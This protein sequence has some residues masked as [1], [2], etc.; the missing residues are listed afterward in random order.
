[1]LRI[2]LLFTLTS[3]FAYT[4]E[5]VRING[6]NLQINNQ[7]GSGETDFFR[8]DAHSF[9]RSH[10]SFDLSFE[11]DLAVIKFSN[12]DFKIEK[13][14][15]PLIKAQ[16]LDIENLQIFYSAI[17]GLNLLF[18]QVI[19]ERETA[20]NFFD[21][22]CPNTPKFGFDEIINSCLAESKTKGESFIFDLDKVKNKLKDVD[23]ALQD[24]NLSLKGRL[25]QGV[26]KGSFWAI[27][28]AE[29]LKEKETIKVKVDK[30][31]LGIFSIKNILFSVLKRNQNKHFKV[32]KPYLYIKL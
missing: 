10:D 25:R 19:F 17:S 3:S 9:L 12:H 8:V 16:G 26:F 15:T 32:K 30:V 11:D 22:K 23:L 4:V 13:I 6:M 2:F 29:Y 1:M 31:K 20:L 21:L 28:K 5:F 18:D 24:G 27:G 14:P 7:E